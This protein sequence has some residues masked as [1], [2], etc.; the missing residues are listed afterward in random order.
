MGHKDFERKIHMW[1]LGHVIQN[2]KLQCHY[3]TDAVSADVTLI[4]KHPKHKSVANT[5]LFD[6][7]LNWHTSKHANYARNSNNN[8]TSQLALTGHA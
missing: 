3:V 6:T 7:H 5:Y 1:H 2:L 4:P 8:P